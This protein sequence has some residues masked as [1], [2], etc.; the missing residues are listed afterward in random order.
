[1]FSTLALAAAI[2]VS[3]S[4]AG[5]L[6]LTNVRTTYGELGA[7]RT[8]TKYLPSDLVFVAFDIEG[9]AVNADGKVAY[10]MSMEVADKAGKPVFKQEKPADSEELLPLGGNRLP[11]RAFVSLK[12]DQEPGNYVCKVTVTDKGTRV[13]KTLEKPFEVIPAA[14]GIIALITTSDI[15]GEQF[16]SPTGVV[17]QNLFVHFALIGIGRG[18]DKK[19]NAAAEMRIFDDQKKPTFP[20]PITAVVPKELPEDEPAL[21]RFAI[22]FNREGN[23]TAEFKAVD[24]VT[25]KTSTVSFPIRVIGR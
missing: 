22:P 19:P 17:G 1:M 20:K 12:P 13:S 24:N 9:L 25:G 10:T 7:V 14:F 18:P 3:A 16:S 5:S 23:F 2:S 11:A 4:Q 21:F 6:N 15:K 8:E